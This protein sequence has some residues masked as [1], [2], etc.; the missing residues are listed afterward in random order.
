MPTNTDLEYRIA[1]SQGNWDTLETGQE[2]VATAGTAV[3]VNGGTSLT[4]PDGSSVVIRADTDNTDAVYVGDDTV[5][6]STGFVI[7][8]GESVELQ[9]KD[10]SNVY[11]DAATSGNSVSWITEVD[12]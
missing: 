3:Q 7:G 5:D 11:I 1:E 9:V 10:I 8:T 6:S 2:T 4:I 12:A